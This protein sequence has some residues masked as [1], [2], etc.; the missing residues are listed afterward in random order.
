MT[1]TS[2]LL[3]LTNGAAQWPKNNLKI[4]LLLFS[5]QVKLPRLNCNRSVNTSATFVPTLP[6]CRRKASC[7]TSGATLDTSS[8][9]CCS[10]SICC[11]SP[12]TRWSSSPCGAS[13]SASPKGSMQ[14]TINR[15]KSKQSQSVIVSVMVVLCILF[16][17]ASSFVPCSH[18]VPAN[19]G[20]LGLY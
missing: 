7:R 13:G 4:L 14:G 17:S 11:S 15:M 8:T 10:A 18:L 6:R 1:N 2:L 5:C 19:E 9:S 12:V 20:P 16:C 3:L